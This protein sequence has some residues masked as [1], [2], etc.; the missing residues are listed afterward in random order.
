LDSIEAPGQRGYHT[1]RPQDAADC[2]AMAA[3]L[4]GE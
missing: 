1:M 2:R 3:R 4:R